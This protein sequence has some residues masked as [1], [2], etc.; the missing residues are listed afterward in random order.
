MIAQVSITRH[1]I[2][3]TFIHDDA[4]RIIVCVIGLIICYAILYRI[5]KNLNK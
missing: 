4:T 2:C 1:P 3:P 5:A